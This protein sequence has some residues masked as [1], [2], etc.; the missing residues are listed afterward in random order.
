MKDRRDKCKYGRI[1]AW[2]SDESTVTCKHCKTE[3]RVDCDSVL[4][5]WLVEKIEE[6][7]PYKTEA[8]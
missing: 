2:D 7:I 1:I 5:Y 8:K 6:Q 4:L 3:Y